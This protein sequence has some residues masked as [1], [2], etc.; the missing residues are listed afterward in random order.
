M[1]LLERIYFLVHAQIIDGLLVVA[2]D[3]KIIDVECNGNLFA[4]R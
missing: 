2:G 4:V 3:E 1:F